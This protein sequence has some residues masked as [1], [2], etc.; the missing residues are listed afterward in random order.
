MQLA[1]LMDYGLFG[2][3]FAAFGI[4]FSIVRIWRVRSDSPEG[5]IAGGQMIGA[6]LKGTAKA[7]LVALPLAL[8]PYLAFVL[9]IR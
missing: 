8:L 5:L 4:W 9:A 1:K 2:V 3:L 7:F 6:V